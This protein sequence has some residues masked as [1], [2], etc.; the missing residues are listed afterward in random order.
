MDFLYNIINFKLMQREE[1]MKSKRSFI[2]L[3]IAVLFIASSNTTLA[4][5]HLPIS[6][7]NLEINQIRNQDIHNKLLPS[8]KLYN[9]SWHQILRSV[10]NVVIGSTNTIYVL[11]YKSGDVYKYSGLPNQW[12]KIGTPARMIALDHSNNTL[13]ALSP[14]GDSV[15]KYNGVP[16]S[17]TKIGNAAGE[18]FAGFGNLIATNPQNGD[19]YR[20]DGNPFKWT[21][22]GGPGKYF[23]VQQTSNNIFGVSPNGTQIYSWDKTPMKWTLAAGAPSGCTINGIRLIPSHIGTF[24]IKCKNT[25]NYYIKALFAP[26]EPWYS[27]GSDYSDF[28][29]GDYS[30]FALS[31]GDVFVWTGTTGNPWVFIYENA[32]AIYGDDP[33]WPICATVYDSH[34]LWC[35]Y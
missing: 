19:L 14:N 7:V 20:Y 2:F 8:V 31:H 23:V 24:I 4:T 10:R 34:D 3:S 21:K 33:R 22:I 15:W 13:Y 12:I 27:V 16:N 32:E 25:N 11:D 1:K 28:A 5:T 35:Y 17:W 30:L 29:Q 9:K 18:I 26:N 6:S